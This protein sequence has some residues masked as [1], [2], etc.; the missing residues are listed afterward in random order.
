MKGFIVIVVVSIGGG[1]GWW[2]GAMV[3][4]GTAIVLSALGSAIAV[5]YVR[6]L[7]AQYT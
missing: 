5:Y 7:L 2:L 3:G 6:R 1:I 4:L